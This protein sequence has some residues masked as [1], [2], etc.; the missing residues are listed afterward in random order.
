MFIFAFI[1]VNIIAHIKNYTIQARSIVFESG[2]GGGTVHYLS[3]PKVSS[4]NNFIDLDYCTAHIAP[5]VEVLEMIA[6]F[7]LGRDSFLA[8][9]ESLTWI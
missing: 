4:V 7:N 9:M 5:F 1:I 2:R 6:T 3:F 8:K